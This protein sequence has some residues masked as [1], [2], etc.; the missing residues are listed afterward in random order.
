MKLTYYIVNYD[1]TKPAHRGP[2]MK[3]LG[4][5]R[6]ASTLI[7]VAKL[8]ASSLLFE[9]EAAATILPYPTK[10]VDVV[11]VGAGM[12]GLQTAVDLQNAGLKV[13]VN[14]FLIW[15]CDMVHHCPRFFL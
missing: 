7:P 6:P 1:H 8:A 2:L 14:R 3:C 15:L 13:K 9:V 10:R 5:H 11:V 4:D 12:R